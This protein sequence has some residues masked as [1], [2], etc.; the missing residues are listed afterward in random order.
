M[1]IFITVV[2]TLFFAALI[3]F[4]LGSAYLTTTHLTAKAKPGSFERF[5]ANRAVDWAHPGSL[6][7]M[8]NPIQVTPEVLTEARDH[9]ARDCAVCH[10]NDGESHT[11]IAQ[12]LYPP[13]PRLKNT[14]MSDGDLFYTIKNGIRFTGMP[15]WS[16]SDEKAWR[17]VAFIHHLPQLTPADIEAMQAINHVESEHHEGEHE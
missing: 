3:A 9:F 6:E 17:L 16:F 4:A 10:G 14:D 15:G 1:K 2:A 7:S 13:V 8:K 5:V 12:G 11:E